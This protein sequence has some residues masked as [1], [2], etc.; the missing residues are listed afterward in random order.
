MTSRC[1]AGRGLAGVS[2]DPEARAAVLLATVVLSEQTQRRPL[3][4]LNPGPFCTPGVGIAT[5]RGV[6][7]ASGGGGQGCCG[8]SH[9]TQGGPCQAGHSSPNGRRTYGL[10]LNVSGFLFWASAPPRL[11]SGA[12]GSGRWGRW[13][14]PWLS[15][16]DKRVRDCELTSRAPGW[17]LSDAI[18]T[19]LA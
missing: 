14:H 11:P 16:A 1:W 18:G 3:V 17:G 5:G 8:P 6:L 9:S 4:V 7:R 12:P 19:A 2:G 15:L 10:L 13:G